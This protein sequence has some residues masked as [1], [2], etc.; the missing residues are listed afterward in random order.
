MRNSFLKTSGAYLSPR[1]CRY[2]SI[3]G[4]ALGV[5]SLLALSACAPTKVVEVLVQ[6]PKCNL[7]YLQEGATFVTDAWAIPDSTFN[8]GEPLRLQMQVSSP[9][10]VNIFY[11]NTSCKVTRL[12]HNLQ[13]PAGVI[14]DFPLRDSS[15]RMTVKP[16]TG[17]E[18]FH[19]VSTRQKLTFLS[20]TDVLSDLGSGISILDMNSDQFYERLD[21]ALN[22]INPY[23]RSMTSLRT[24]VVSL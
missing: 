19:F 5:A 2:T 10:Y 11:I 15:I 12:L 4:R 16:P 3:I 1:T 20:T 9:S 17:E 7:L 14:T 8:V 22:R 6:T 23:E 24:T 21:Q 13:V 18:V